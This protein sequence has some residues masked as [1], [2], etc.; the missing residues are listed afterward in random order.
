M[1]LKTL[2]D[3][4]ESLAEV[5]LSSSDK[6]FWIDTI[7]AELKQSAIEDIKEFNPNQ[8]SNM[9]TAYLALITSYTRE[10]LKGIIKYIKWKFNITDEDL[11]D[12]K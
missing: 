11:K 8:P 7:S 12:D 3:L 9:T 5:Y 1:K 2:E 6:V 4:K 10:E